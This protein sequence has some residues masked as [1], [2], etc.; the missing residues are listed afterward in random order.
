[1]LEE[2]AEVA[3]ASTYNEPKHPD[4]LQPHRRAARPRAG[5]RPRL[6]GRATSASRSASPTPSPPSPSRA[7]P[8]IWSSAPTRCSARWRGECLGDEE[9]GRLRPDP[10][11]GS[12]RGRVRSRPRSPAPTPP[13]PK[14]DWGAFFAGTRRQA[15]PAAHLPLPAPALLARPR[16]RHGRPRRRRPRRPPSTR[17]SRAAIED[18]SGEGLALHRP[19]LAADPPLARRPRG[20]RHGAAARHRLRRAGAAGGGAGRAPSVEELTLQAPLVL[21][22]AGGGRRPGRRSPG[23]TRT[24]GARSRSTPAPEGEEAGVDPA[25][26]SGALA[27]ARP[28]APPSRLGCLAARGRRAGRRRVPLRPPRR[29]RASTTGR[30][31]R[32]CTAA[33]RRRRAGLRRGRPCPRS[34]PR[35]RAL[36]DPPGPAGLG[37]ARRSPSLAPS[38]NRTGRGCPSPGAGY[39][40]RRRAP[41][42]CGCA[43]PRRGRAS[44]CRPPT[45][46]GAPVATVGSLVPA[47]A[48]R[49]TARSRRRRGARGAAGASSGPRSRSPS[50]PTAPAE[51]ELLR[52][53]IEAE[54][55]AAEAA[56][57]AAPRR[58]GGDPAM[59]R[60]RVQGR[61][62]P[63]ADHPRRAMAA[64]GARRPTP[65]PPRSGASSARPSPST[66][67]A[68]P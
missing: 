66:P 55:G 32:G 24:G 37:P 63:G 60:R 2:F 31:S 17:C 15:R 42:S 47:P 57:E 38:E 5:H 56:A 27:A 20:R 52:C 9:R 61:S 51:V 43:S 59:A 33:W 14:L 49:R 26:P 11:R 36:R 8:P 39:R 34:R 16:P 35:G 65:P 64:R 67:A 21:A 28:G 22:E 48:R 3:E 10:A 41:G 58:P 46:P 53:E 6:L 30:P 4:R 50:G 23:P 40:C 25:T 54:A 44:P 45:A 12:R 62:P 18:P 1:M 19:P 29:A 13:A 68:S 7:P